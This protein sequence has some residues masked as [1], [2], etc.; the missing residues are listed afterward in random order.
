[1]SFPEILYEKSHPLAFIYLDRPDIKNAFTVPMLDSLCRALKDA[2][3][4]PD[5]KVIVLGGQG[6]AF[7]AGGNIKDMAEGKLTSWNMKRYLSEHVQR[8]PLFMQ[9]VD[10]AIIASIDGPAFGAGS[11]LAMAC[12]LRIASDRAVIGSTFVRIGLAPGDGGAFFLPRLVGLSR[13]LEILL[14]GR[15]V[16]MDEALRIGLVDRVVKNE[17]LREETRKYAMEIAAW[18]A[19][20]LRATKRAVYQGLTSDL[21]GHLDYMSSQVALL[22]ETEEHRKA[23]KKLVEK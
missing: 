22:S 9:Q 20:S 1:M 18:P 23:I 6:G 17:D 4:D 12:D 15:A 14:T 7:C 8:V 10:K 11:D 16:A 2:N 13:A 19:A 21:G 5:I 3:Q